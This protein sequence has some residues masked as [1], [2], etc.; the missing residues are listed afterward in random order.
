M[1]SVE[2]CVSIHVHVV[3]R[4][5][6][7]CRPFKLS[8]G[9]FNE[10]SFRC[11][12]VLHEAIEVIKCEGEV[13]SFSEL[14]SSSPSLLTPHL[15]VPPPSLSLQYCWRWT[16]YLFGIDVI[17]TYYPNTG[18]VLASVIVS[19]FACCLFP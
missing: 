7:H 19:S 18:W 8:E 17:I 6:S 9:Q 2:H 5:L 4:H 12:R 10:H 11:G 1:K 15:V 13:I 14:D 16:G 3:Y